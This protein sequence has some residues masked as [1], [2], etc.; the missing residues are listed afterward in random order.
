[1]ALWSDLAELS[2]DDG[3]D[4]KVVRCVRLELDD[5]ATL[6]VYKAEQTAGSVVMWHVRGF[7]ESGG[8]APEERQAVLLRTQD[9]RAIVKWAGGSG[10]AP[11]RGHAPKERPL[12]DLSGVIANAIRHRID[13]PAGSDGKP[14]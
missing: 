13:G 11:V 9:G 14:D 5:A 4:A 2:V 8:S 7:F 6:D 1:M 12:T 10:M 3:E